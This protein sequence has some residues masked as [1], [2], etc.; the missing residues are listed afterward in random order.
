MLTEPGKNNADNELDN[1]PLVQSNDDEY[2][3]KSAHDTA[4][5]FE[6]EADE[7]SFQ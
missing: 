6:V 2:L 3:E 7:V 1:D 4:D 5:E